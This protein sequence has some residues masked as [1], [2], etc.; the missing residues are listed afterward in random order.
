MHN[1][2]IFQDYYISVIIDRLSHT[3][4]NRGCQAVVF[5]PFDDLNTFK[6]FDSTDIFPNLFHFA[7]I[8]RFF[9]SVRVN[10]EMALIR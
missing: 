2:S 6:T 1:M 9:G 8:G 3:G 10:D 5:S 7:L 4:D